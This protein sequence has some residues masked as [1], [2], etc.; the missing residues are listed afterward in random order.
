MWSESKRSG[1]AAELARWHRIGAIMQS[2]EDK[3]LR[4]WGSAK[5]LGD[6]GPGNS[7][8]QRD[9][10]GSRMETKTCAFLK[11]LADPHLPGA[12]ASCITF[13]QLV[14]P[15]PRL[16]QKERGRVPLGLIP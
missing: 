3:G 6:L 7:L 14:F 11:R 12:P 4:P 10:V 15:G 1:S 5:H 9:H 16:S 13:L 2:L 8:D